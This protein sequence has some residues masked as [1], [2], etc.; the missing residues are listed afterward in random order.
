MEKN[1]KNNKL[2]WLVTLLNIYLVGIPLYIFFGPNSYKKVGAGS[3]GIKACYSNQRVLQGAVEMY[4]MDSKEMMS[5]YDEDILIKGDY[6]KS[7]PSKPSPECQ[8]LGTDLDGVGSVYCTYH[9]DLEGRTKGTYKEEIDRFYF[10][11]EYFGQ[12]FNRIPE[13]IVWPLFIIVI[14]LNM[15]RI[16]R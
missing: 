11:K 6:L 5:D 4:N 1:K 9:G 10:I 7:R 2:R 3:G 12:C 16:I 14:I 13:S 8:Y 15:L